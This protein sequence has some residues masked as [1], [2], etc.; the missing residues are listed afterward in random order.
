MRNSKVALGSAGSIDSIGSSGSILSIGSTGSILSIG[1]SGSI[2]SI[3]SAGS[4][5]SIASVGSV[6]SST[7]NNRWIVS[8]SLTLA[9]TWITF[10][11]FGKNCGYGKS[12]PR[13]TRTSAC[14]MEAYP[15]V[16]PRSPVRPTSN[17]LSYSICSLPRSAWV[18]GACKAPASISNSSCAPAQPA[19][20]R[21]AIRLEP[22]RMS[23]ACCKPFFEGMISESFSHS[24]MPLASQSQCFVAMLPGITNTATPRFATAVR[25]A[26]G[27]TRSS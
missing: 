16:K 17:R 11:R 21:I 3:G 10:A 8:S 24:P 9:S 7:R 4:V 19:P 25:M 22:F 6:A 5:L 14:F 1:S 13:M 15:D 23:A 26:M 12:L 2:L 18:M 20:P 27:S